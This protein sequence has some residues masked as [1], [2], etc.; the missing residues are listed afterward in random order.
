[1]ILQTKLFDKLY[2]FGSVKEVLAKANE[3]KSGD[4]LAGVAAEDATERVAAKVVLSN[5]T[6]EDIYNN[7]V[8]PYEDDEVTR[9]IIDGVN[10]RIYNE[11]KNW[12]VSDLREWV[13]SDTTTDYDIKRIRQG[14]TSEMAAAI[15]KLMTNMDLVIAAKKIIVE[16]TANT[17]IGRPGTFSSRLQTNHPT[18]DIDGIM[19]GIME[20][21]S[22]GIGDA[23]IGLNPNDDSVDSVVKILNK[24]EDFR[25]QWDVPTQCSVL[26]HVT[27]QMEAIK[28]GAPVGLCFQSIA[29]SEKGNTAFG[30][31]A[32]M[33][34]EAY[35]LTLHEGQAA[36]PNVMY[37]ETGEGSELSAEANFGADELTMESRCYGFAKKF[38]PYIVNTVVGFIGPE[39][40]YNSKQVIRAGLEDHFMGKLQ[41]ISMG[42]DVCYTNHMKAD[43]NDAENL[44]VLLGA[45]G[46]NYIMGV[47]HADDVMLNYESTGFQETATIREI[48][49]YHPIKEFED[50]MEKMDISHNGQLTERAGDAS[51]FLN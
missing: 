38:D 19:A 12:T 44:A 36:G 27:T 34:S 7:P 8:V 32:D 47:P 45:A 1:M 2:R 42:C 25:A 10:K 11:I 37:F 20:G 33:I 39:Y 30:I 5:L 46:C 6:L 51:I 48:F 28:R 13:L 49:G 16:K 14:I 35:D 50:W 18:D 29:G 15:T 4:E 9:I 17:T 22:M 40:L 41:G 31:N 24:F 23:V 21:L 43:Q 3:V 26:A